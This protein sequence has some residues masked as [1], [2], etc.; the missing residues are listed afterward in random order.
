MV[1]SIRAVQPSHSIAYGFRVRLERTAVFPWFRFWAADKVGDI[2]SFSLLL[3]GFV[4][5]RII[6]SRG[7]KVIRRRGGGRMERRESS[8][9]SSTS[10]A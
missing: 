8:R 3:L 10:I 2:H 6:I 9:S 1:S 4:N 7:W 5:Y